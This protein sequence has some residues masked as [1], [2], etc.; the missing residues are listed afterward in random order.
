MS[1]EGGSTWPERNA[2]QV[3][4]EKHF[5][6]A[7]AMDIHSLSEAVTAYR[8]EVQAE[9]AELKRENSRLEKENRGLSRRCVRLAGKGGEHE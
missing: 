7:T 3:W 2:V 6:G 9:L 4:C 1:D 5:L 8:L